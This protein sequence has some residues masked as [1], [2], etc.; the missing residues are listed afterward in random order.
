LRAI[1]VKLISNVLIYVLNTVRILQ[2]WFPTFPLSTSLI[3]SP[4]SLNTNNQK[5]KKVVWLV[6][7]AHNHT[8]S[9]YMLVFTSH[10]FLWTR[11]FAK[12]AQVTGNLKIN[13]A[14]QSIV[15]WEGRWTNS[16]WRYHMVIF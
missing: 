10:G 12:I 11:L 5:V 6:Y 7:I 3:C 1:D 9:K 16:T 4:V 14:S 2:Q 15:E 8:L 13:N